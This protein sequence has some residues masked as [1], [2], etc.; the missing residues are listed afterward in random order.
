MG[1]ESGQHDEIPGPTVDGSH[2][3]EHPESISLWWSEREHFVHKTY[4]GREKINA[5]LT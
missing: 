5:I 3:L 1:R 2:C 4:D